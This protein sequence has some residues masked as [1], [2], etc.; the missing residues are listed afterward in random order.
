VSRGKPAGNAAALY[1]GIGIGGGAGD[2]IALGVMSSPGLPPVTVFP[3]S[4]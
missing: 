4:G 1:I 3:F 2:L